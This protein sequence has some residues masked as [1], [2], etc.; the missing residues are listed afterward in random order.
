MNEH[1]V[2]IHKLIAVEEKVIV[3]LVNPAKRP[4]ETAALFGS[5]FSELKMPR[6]KARLI[7]FQGF[8]WV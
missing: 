5:G 6:I 2:K 4:R 7:E 8:I 3:G 1:F